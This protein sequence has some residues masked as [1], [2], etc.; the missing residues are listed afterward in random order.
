LCR[1]PIP[2][3]TRLALATAG[4]VA[5]WAA[6]PPR[7]WWWMV[8]A[9]VALLVGTVQG[10]PARR[11]ALIGSAFGLGWAIP[12]F[13]WA[14]AFTGVGYVLLVLL[15][16]AFPAVAAWLTPARASTTALPGALVLVEWIR[17]RWP[18]GGLP[19]GSPTLAQVDA[20]WV[21]VAAYGGPL[22]ALLVAAVAGAAAVAMMQRDWRTVLGGAL[23]VLVGVSVPAVVPPPTGDIEV[24][25]V[26]GGGERGV[27]AV[28]A[29]FAAVLDRHI[30]ASAGLPSGLDLVVWPEGV[31]DVPT[32]F[33]A[34]PQ[35]RRLAAM[36]RR[37]RATFL[38]GVVEDEPGGRFRNSAVVVSPSGELLDR[39]EKTHRVP[40]GEYVPWRDVLDGLV[41]VSLVPRDATVGTGPRVVT[42]AGT[43]V[44]VMISYEGSFSRY[45]RDA[46]RAG[47][48]VLAIPTNAASYVTEDVPAQQVAGARLRA[49]E[50]GRDVLQAAP[51]GYSA[52]VLAGGTLVTRSSLE[53]PAILTRRVSTRRGITPYV[54]A[55]D[56]PTIALAVALLVAGRAIDVSRSRR[57][58]EPP[59]RNGTASQRTR[60]SS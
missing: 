7:G 31:V 13:A 53:E 55:G 45:A 60:S 2:I 33:Q 6:L 37:S 12:T 57:G 34:S 20:A 36:A 35:R 54:R 58:M 10:Q 41:D 27:P 52:I 5:L 14:F 25:V 3:I 19:L 4:G 56:L 46:A 21:E 11:R 38:V 24:A 43:T 32:R 47:A 16:A 30:S 9:A 17:W 42:A 50:T 44:G 1:V 23:F 8:P 40:F 28:R 49:I 59:P 48:N 22:L 18:L 15:Q 26:Q 39:F 51:T 29:D